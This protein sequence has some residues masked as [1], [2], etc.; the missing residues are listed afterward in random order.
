MESCQPIKRVKDKKKNLTKK[1]T[2][3]TDGGEEGVLAAR[4]NMQMLR[5]L[6]FSKHQLSAQFF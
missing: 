6:H 4:Y 3:N 5:N 2:S 1:W